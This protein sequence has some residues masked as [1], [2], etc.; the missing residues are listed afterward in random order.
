MTSDP[1]IAIDGLHFAECLRWRDGLLYFCDMYGDTV[2]SFDPATGERR[3]VASIFHP[4]GIGWLPDGQLLT[5]ASEDRRIFA[6][7]ET[8]NVGN[9]GYDL[10][11]E[12]PRATQLILVDADGTI[13]RQPGEL[14]F[15]NGM[16][17]RSDGTLV[18][19]ETF[20]HRLATFDV[21]ADGALTPTGT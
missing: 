12:E 15:P 10:F 4:G 19:A 18:V 13:S 1:D 20:A 14:V 21:A 6:V 9:F 5:V 16:V 11:A 7:S 17:R 8:A 2:E 3:I